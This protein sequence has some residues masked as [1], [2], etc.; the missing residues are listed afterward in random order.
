MNTLVIGGSGFIGEYL[1]RALVQDGVISVV[2]SGMN[3]K[4]KIAGVRYEEIDLDKNFLELKKIMNEVD[5]IVW[6]VQPDIG[7]MKNILSVIKDFGNVKKIVYLSTLLVYSDSIRK[8]NEE[9]VPEP[10]TDYEKTKFEEEKILEEFVKNKNCNLCIARLGNVYGDVKNR[11]VVSRLMA[12]VFNLAPFELEG[13]GNSVRDY[14]FVEDVAD[15]LPKMAGYLQ[16]RA[17]EIFNVGTGVGHS[18]IELIGLVES[19]AGV[20]IT[21]ESRAGDTGQ[22]SAIGSIAKVQNMLHFSPKFDLTNGLKK[23]YNNYSKHYKFN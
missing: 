6:A 21:I 5:K 23:T 8:Q 19:V 16:T 14:V 9:A 18:L 7:R 13:K 10:E 11:G 17:V 20:K 3:E 12:S 15:L 2:R 1:C 4:E 22:K